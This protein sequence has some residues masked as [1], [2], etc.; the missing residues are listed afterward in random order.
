MAVVD[1]QVRSEKWNIDISYQ[2][3]HSAGPPDREQYE[4]IPSFLPVSRALT[5]RAAHSL[6]ARFV[7]EPTGKPCNS[8]R[9]FLSVFRYKLKAN[10]RRG[11]Y[12]QTPVY[13]I[14]SCES[15]SDYKTKKLLPYKTKTRKTRAN[16]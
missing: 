14:I 13:D 11:T 3:P 2:D 7:S 12:K 8:F 9:V 10:M 15:S 6:N 16:L 1:V 4:S 5:A